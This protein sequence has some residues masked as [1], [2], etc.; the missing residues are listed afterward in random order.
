MGRDD[1]INTIVRHKQANGAIIFAL[2]ITAIFFL[3]GAYMVLFV[4]PQQVSDSIRVSAIPIVNKE[5]LSTMT[6]GQDVAISGRLVDNPTIEGKE[7]VAFQVE[8]WDVRFNNGE[9]EGRWWGETDNWPALLVVIS[10]GVAQTNG[11]IP[12]L[13]KGALHEEIEARG[14]GKTAK[15][16]GKPL[17]HGSLRF[18]GVING[19]QVS[20]VGTTTNDATIIPEYFYAGTR[21][22]LLESLAFNAQSIRIIGF[23][24]MVVAVVIGSVALL[25]NRGKA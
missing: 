17:P 19:D 15:Y 21:E 13:L 7:F 3:I 8:R 24:L 22:E 12:L 11:G 9:Y 14:G 2:V 23:I 1:K 16:N 10:G 18:S 20:I 5:R 4:H 6:S 25:K